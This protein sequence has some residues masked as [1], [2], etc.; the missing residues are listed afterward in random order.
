MRY[1]NPLND[2]S[3][4]QKVISTSKKHNLN[5]AVITGEM[6]IDGKRVATG[7][8]DT[9]FMMASIFYIDTGGICEHFVER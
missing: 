6:D 9:R 5:E 2:S 1:S 3:Y 8:M 7:V 4:H